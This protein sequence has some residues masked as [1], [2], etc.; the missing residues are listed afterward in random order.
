M[1]L[2]TVSRLK[3]H[4]S[5][6]C[7]ALTGSSFPSNRFGWC[8]GN[9]NTPS[10]LLQWRAQLWPPAHSHFTSILTVRDLSLWPP[11]YT[12]HTHSNSRGFIIVA[13]ITHKHTVS[14]HRYGFNV[15]S[16]IPTTLCVGGFTQVLEEFVFPL[17]GRFMQVRPSPTCYSK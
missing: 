1:P 17:A 5:Y 10:A 7:F 3:L 6:R 12:F 14:C 16:S 13:P 4:T 15:L 8:H 11:S 9:D 2:G